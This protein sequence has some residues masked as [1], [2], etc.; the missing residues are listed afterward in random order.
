LL[1]FANSFTN[2]AQVQV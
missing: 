2:M 1:Q